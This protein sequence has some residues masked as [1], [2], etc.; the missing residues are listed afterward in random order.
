MK[1]S[2]IEDYSKANDIELILFDGFDD[3][4]LGLGQRYTQAEGVVYSKQKMREILMSRDKMTYE[5][6]EEY[7]SFNTYCLWAGEHTP[8]LLEDELL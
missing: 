4:I 2:E 8:I 3:A 7:L 1:R 6:A 5:D